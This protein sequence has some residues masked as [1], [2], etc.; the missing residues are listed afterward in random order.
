MVHA[1]LGC[2]HSPRLPLSNHTNDTRD[3][4][5]RKAPCA[6]FQEMHTCHGASWAAT[7]GAQSGAGQMASVS[8]RPCWCAS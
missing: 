3:A 2:C 5:M 4:C 7:V 6:A 1:A 8:G